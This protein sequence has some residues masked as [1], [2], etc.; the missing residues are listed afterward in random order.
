MR[1]ELGHYPLARTT[2]EG[3]GNRNERKLIPLMAVPP[4]GCKNEYRHHS[5]PPMEDPTLFPARRNEGAHNGKHEKNRAE[6]REDRLFCD[7]PIPRRVHD[8]KTAAPEKVIRI[9]SFRDSMRMPIPDRGRH[10]RNQS[11]KPKFPTR[12]KRPPRS[13]GL[14][15][16][17]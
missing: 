13:G 3:G 16:A 6:T 9:K 8:S 5:E 2:R 10:K 7:L 17:V 11:E 4:P 15:S 12:E 14:Q 1:S